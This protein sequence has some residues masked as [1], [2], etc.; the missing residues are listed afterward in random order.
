MPLL[1]IIKTCYIRLM[2]QIQLMYGEQQFNDI[3]QYYMQ[4]Y[5]I[6]DVLYC[7]QLPPIQY[8][9]SVKRVLTSMPILNFIRG[10]SLV[11]CAGR[12]SVFLLCLCYS[13]TLISCQEIHFDGLSKIYMFI[14][15]LPP[16]GV[17]NN[18]A[19]PPEIINHIL[20]SVLYK[21]C[22]QNQISQNCIA[23]KHSIRC[24][25]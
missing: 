15:Q 17:A 11:I 14:E 23:K 1:Q 7:T 19:H 5:L 6:G 24:R 3:E 22:H 10:V 8:Q 21:N 4:R 25:N 12:Y 2:I 16:L 20:V 9:K 18:E 13:C